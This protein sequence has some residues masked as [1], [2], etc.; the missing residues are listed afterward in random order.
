MVN[1]PARD[2]LLR[3]GEQYQLPRV[4][5]GLRPVADS[6]ASDLVSL[7]ERVREL[8]A[9]DRTTSHTAAHHLIESGGKRV[10]PTVCMLAARCFTPYEPSPEVIGLS[11]VAEAAHNSTLL[12]DDV[13]DLGEMRRG[14]PAA[15]VLFGNGA[16]V[17]GG[18]LLL[19]QALRLIDEAGVA[20]LMTSMIS[21]LD[22]MITAEAFQLEN[23]GRVDVT[24]A[25]YF[26]I[27]DG[28]TAS[29]FEWA[30]EA[31]ARAAGAPQVAVDGLVR[32][33]K[34]LGYAFQLLDDLLDLT[35]DP[36]VLGK[37]VLQ[38]VAGGTVTYPILLALADRPALA[39]RLAAAS[40][41]EEDARL[42]GDLLEAVDASGAVG[43]TRRLV[44]EHTA[45]SLAA[46]AVIEPTP[47]SH[48]LSCMA[49]ALAERAQ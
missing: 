16:S 17:L 35:K 26:S 29:L 28:K 10:R 20:G 47:A 34:E 39:R 12:H 2:A 8:M 42:V 32:F 19:I 13:I 14:R 46:L 41:G 21:V 23:R 36:E 44:A 1:V 18:D 31:G 49:K 33:G 27:I 37:G 43:E 30:M 9:G 25:E 48:A 11:M 4:R 45:A 24:P 5:E 7:E 15:R 6:L 38:D 3:L 22:R 40:E